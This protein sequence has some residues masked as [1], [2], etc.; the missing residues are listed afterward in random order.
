MNV[1]TFT[2]GRKESRLPVLAAVLLSFVMVVHAESPGEKNFHQLP[3]PPHNTQAGPTHDG[4]EIGLWTEKSQYAGNEIRNVWIFAR[5]KQG[6]ATTIG[7]GGSLYKESFLYITDSRN[8]K[9]S[10]IPIGG[11]VD[12]APDGSLYAGGISGSLANLPAGNY[13]LIWK[14]E[15]WVSNTIQIT[16]E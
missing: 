15:K 13:K 5:K 12:G 11:G 1:L 9:T 7:V 14:T 6:S 16:I 3:S 2:T 10:K 8:K 4:I